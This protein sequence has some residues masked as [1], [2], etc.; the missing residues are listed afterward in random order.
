MLYNERDAWF[1]CFLSLSDIHV[2]MFC[3]KKDANPIPDKDTCDFENIFK[4]FGQV[5]FKSL[6]A[7]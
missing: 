1:Q 4:V 5:A 2:N 6:W 3:E 7:L